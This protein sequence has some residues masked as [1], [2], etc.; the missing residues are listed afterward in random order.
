[1]KDATYSENTELKFAADS[2][3]AVNW[4][5]TIFPVGVGVQNGANI[6]VEAGTYTVVF[7][8]LLGKYYFITQ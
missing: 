6:P 4:G 2:G 7:N 8:D 1:M 5:S 3:W